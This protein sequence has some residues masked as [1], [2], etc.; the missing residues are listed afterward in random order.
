MNEA[1]PELQ[2]QT[3]EPVEGAAT[4]EV[5]CLACGTA[6]AAYWDVNGRPACERCKN[7]VLEARRASHVVP[8]LKAAGLG[9]VAAAVGALLYYAVA[10]ITGYEIGL[11]SIVVGLLVGFAVRKGS[12]GRGGWRYQALAMFLCYAAI[13]GTYLPRVLEAAKQSEPRNGPVAAAAQGSASTPAVPEPGASTPPP[14]A[15]APASVGLGEFL[16]AVGMLVA[17][18]L[19]LPFLAGFENLMG[20][21]IIGIALFEA[22][23]V[24][25]APPFSLSGPF[26]VSTNQTRHG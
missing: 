13:C 25:K 14:V 16:Q 22:W 26:T 4:G 17:L 7:A 18:T 21:L 1:T 11:I 23:K 12:G 24:N 3:A 6:L 15:A 19:A 2:F 10:E 5:T 8:L 9:V 20:L